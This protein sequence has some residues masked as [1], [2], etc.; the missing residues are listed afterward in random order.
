MK[1]LLII[2]TFFLLKTSS[3]FACC[4]EKDYRLFPIGQVNEKVLFIEFDLFRSCKIGT[5]A[6][7]DNEFWV[8]GI[9]NL[10][11]SIGDSL[12][13]VETIDTINIK[14]CKC[15][16]NEHYLNT[17]YKSKLAISYQKA[18]KIAKQIDGFKFA[19]PKSIVFNDTLNTIVIEDTSD[20][21]Y[22]YVVK[23]KDLISIDLEIEEII[24]C[25]P[26]K[27]A[28]IRTYETE[29]FKIT[30]LRL[31]CHLLDEIALEHNKKQFENI[32]TAFWKEQAQWHGIS[33]DYWIIKDNN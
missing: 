12:I 27:I 19:Q 6:G 20:S 9:V 17:E 29:S 26:D 1:I 11:S 24:S 4:A 32:E 15:T 10:I 18:F 22:S 23:Y 25:Y 13:L 21:S 2:T 16:Y 30:I 31:R 7:L 3:V 14:E 33:K 28:E 5:G 8:S